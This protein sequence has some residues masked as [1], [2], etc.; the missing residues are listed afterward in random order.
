MRYRWL[1]LVLGV[2]LGS[3][4]GLLFA[5]AEQSTYTASAYGVVVPQER[6][7][8]AF[9]AATNVAQGYARVATEPNLIATGL[10]TQR[11][12]LAPDQVQRDVRVSASPETPIIEIFATRPDPDEAGRLADAVVDG[13]VANS[14]SLRPS[15][16]YR[17]QRFVATSTPTTPSNP[18]G[19]FYAGLGGSA[20][21][22]IAGLIA[23]GLG[24]TTSSRQLMGAPRFVRPASD[25]GPAFA[26]READYSR[27]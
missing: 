16:G 20:G 1:L 18:S 5:A 27:D 14:M 10:A 23:F 13:L 9:Q 15:I 17:V 7:P 3:L 19:L 6:D 12:S 11:L 24:Q 21:L 26:A 25:K 2:I 8:A 4:G 22:M